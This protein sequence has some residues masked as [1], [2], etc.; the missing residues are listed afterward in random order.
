[1]GFG[2]LEMG[3]ATGF[4]LTA[5]TKLGVNSFNTRIF[6]KDLGQYCVIVYIC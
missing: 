6:N 5:G 2:A 4:S 3:R 1:M